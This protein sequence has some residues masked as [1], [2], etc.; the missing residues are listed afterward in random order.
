MPP[1]RLGKAAYERGLTSEKRVLEACKLEKRPPWMLRARRATRIEDHSGID[2]VVETEVG[3]LAIQVKSSEGGKAHFRPRPLLNVGIVVVRED[4][5]PNVLLNSVVSQLRPIRASHLK[6]LDKL[7]VKRLVPLKRQPPVRAEAKPAK[8]PPIRTTSIVED[9]PAAGEPSWTELRDCLLA[10]LL[11]PAARRPVSDD[12]IR[13]ATEAL[14]KRSVR[15]A[16]IVARC[17]FARRS[18]S[19][20]RI[21]C[22]SRATGSLHRAMSC[23]R[24]SLACRRSWMAKT[25]SFCRTCRNRSPWS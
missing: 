10:A 1:R 5:S 12:E 11:G 4:D 15:V 7:G 18:I 22:A 9:A 16:E 14:A 13:I 2:V 25:T 21:G 8:E 6:A 19:L 24:S 20:K 17:R 3:S 23:A